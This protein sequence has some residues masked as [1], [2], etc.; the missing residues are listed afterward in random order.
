MRRADR[1][2][3]D[4]PAHE[5]ILQEA[6]VC[7]LALSGPAGPYVVPLNYGW[8]WPDDQP[9]LWFHGASEGLKLELLRG[10]PRVVVSL[11]TGTELVVGSSSAQ[12]SMRYR[13]LLGRGTLVEVTDEAGKIRGLD[14]LMAH[15]APGQDFSHPAEAVKVTTVLRLV[16]DEFHAK[17]RK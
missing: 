10:A 16:L 8:E 15:Y 2:V 13:S 6:Q 4:R 12:Y 11:V 1:A 17:E 9:I 7:H 3:T 5:A 14:C